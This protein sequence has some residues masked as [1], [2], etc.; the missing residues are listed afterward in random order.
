MRNLVLFVVG[1]LVVAS[2]SALSAH[3]VKG[4]SSPALATA[5]VSSP[6]AGTDAPLRVQWGSSDTRLRVACF[7][8]ANTSLPR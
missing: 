8:A 1:A 7:F 2:L 6:S 4:L 5:F 3:V